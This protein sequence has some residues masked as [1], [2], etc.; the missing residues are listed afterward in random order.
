MFDKHHKANN[1]SGPQ[2]ITHKME[3]VEVCGLLNSR[4]R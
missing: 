2:E 4:R 1:G 3:K